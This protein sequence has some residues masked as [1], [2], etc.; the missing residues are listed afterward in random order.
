[1]CATKIEVS[2]QMQRN[3][4]CSSYCQN[5]PTLESQQE[6]FLVLKITNILDTCGSGA[7][8]LSRLKAP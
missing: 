4:L 5:N 8:L 1:M 2:E 6:V 3:L 7:K